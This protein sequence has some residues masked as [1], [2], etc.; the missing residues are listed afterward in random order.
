MDGIGHKLEHH[1]GSRHITTFGYHILAP[2]KHYAQPKI[3]KFRAHRKIN[4][5]FK[6]HHYYRQI[7]A[8]EK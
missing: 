2:P 7:Y 4:D 3:S 6:S 5:I 1:T 8:T